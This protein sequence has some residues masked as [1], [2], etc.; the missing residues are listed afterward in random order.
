M[1]GFFS[2]KVNALLIRGK[3]HLR[4][5][6]PPVLTPLVM[7]LHYEIHVSQNACIWPASLTP[8]VPLLTKGRRSYSYFIH[9]NDTVGIGGYIN[10]SPCGALI[11]SWV[12]ASL[13][14]ASRSHWL[15]T[16]VGRTPLDE[17]SAQRREQYFPIHTSYK[18]QTSMPPA[19]FDPTIPASERPQ[20]HAL[21]S[22]VTGT[23][24]Y[25]IYSIGYEN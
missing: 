16:T 23:D 9:S 17:W 25:R 22:A 20:T 1:T 7:K 5:P 14:R 8:F 21:D 12:M 13:Y 2:W 15:D 11:R 4:S 6:P 10:F 24:G 18:R 3:Q 19:G